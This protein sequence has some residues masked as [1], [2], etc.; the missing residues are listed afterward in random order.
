MS[1]DTTSVNCHDHDWRFTA[2]FIPFLADYYTQSDNLEVSVVF[3]PH[4][5][6]LLQV[7]L[8][9]LQ[10]I[11]EHSFSFS[12]LTSQ[13]RWLLLFC[14]KI[15]SKLRNDYLLRK[16][17]AFNKSFQHCAEL[18]NVRQFMSWGSRWFGSLST[19][20]QHKVML[21]SWLLPQVLLDADIK[22]SESSFAPSDIA[23][24]VCYRG[25]DDGVVNG[26]AGATSF[27][28]SSVAY[29]LMDTAT[30]SGSSADI[31]LG[32]ISPSADALRFAKQMDDLLWNVCSSGD[33]CV[34]SRFC[35]PGLFNSPVEELVDSDSID[36]VKSFVNSTFLREERG[37]PVDAPRRFDYLWPR[38]RVDGDRD[39]DCLR[40]NTELFD[41]LH[42]LVLSL[43]VESSRLHICSDDS[44]IG[45]GEEINML[46]MKSTAVETP[47]SVGG[48]T[49]HSVSA[50]AVRLLSSCYFLTRLVVASVVDALQF[51]SVSAKNFD[52]IFNRMYVQS[53]SLLD[54]VQSMNSLSSVLLH[55]E[56]TV[57]GWC[58]GQTDRIVGAL[59][60]ATVVMHRNVRW[61]LIEG[62]H[63]WD[64]LR[65]E[66][67]TNHKLAGTDKQLFNSEKT[68]ARIGMMLA[69]GIPVTEVQDYLGWCCVTRESSRLSNSLV[70][71]IIDW[72]QV[73]PKLLSYF[74]SAM[75]ALPEG[76]VFARFP[77]VSEV[78]SM[79][80][81]IPDARLQLE[82]SRRAMKR[83]MI[84]PTDDSEQ[85]EV[86]Q[87]LDDLILSKIRVLVAIFCDNCED[88]RSG[89]KGGEISADEL[90][91]FQ[92]FEKQSEDH[93]D[94]IVGLC[95]FYS[96]FAISLL[97]RK[98]CASGIQNRTMYV[99]LCCRHEHHFTVVIFS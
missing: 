4:A 17:P 61:Q 36:F 98:S 24:T 80:P 32:D 43:V 89:K 66:S 11:P 14:A 33:N 59:I 64:S 70:T 74:V 77:N 37:S 49:D 35:E 31:T 84:A 3:L 94:H 22:V 71:T 8:K 12:W 27:V 73:A 44:R 55:D 95:V 47:S 85:T 87:K 92:V 78:L 7:F 88:P 51:S 97:Q 29:R 38:P 30:H 10:Q 16:V 26:G 79:G 25:A 50:N 18:W 96:E 2:V 39:G 62:P 46:I 83:V 99:Q 9:H 5:L 6:T 91:L 86:L 19:V 20:D 75:H 65:I 93:V 76:N 90:S 58:N 81:S 15:S 72:L 1:T 45:W 68:L 69:T 40:G 63:I 34:L 67:R 21:N 48:A 53:V 13:C 56:L 42:M 82:L 41:L 54:N 52:S 23:G 57:E 60:R 28:L